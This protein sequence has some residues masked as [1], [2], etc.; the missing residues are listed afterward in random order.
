MYNQQ[1]LI[2]FARAPEYGNV[3]RRL[4]KDIGKQQALDFYTNT[5]KALLTQM[6]AGD[7]SLTVA[8]ATVGAKSHPLFKNHNSV[9]QSDGDLGHRMATALDHFHG[10]PRIIIGSDIPSIKPAHILS[11]FEALLNH[12]VVFGPAC[13]G[14]FWLVGCNAHFNA[15][16]SAESLFMKNVRWSTDQA[17]S[18]T[19]ATLPDNC[20]VATVSTLADVDDGQ[21]YQH[22]LRDRP[23]P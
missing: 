17:L 11:A 4:A 10:S 13:D 16:T 6:E 5:L 3:K 18:D 2:I 8:A 23:C 12:D 19:L 22:Y 21:A 15:G 9:Q 20:R 1:Q 14:G 7:W